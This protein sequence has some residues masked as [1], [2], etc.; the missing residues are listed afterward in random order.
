MT[1]EG[2]AAQKA[3]TA[4]TVM[5]F[6]RQLTEQQLLCKHLPCSQQKMAQILH[7]LVLSQQQIQALRLTL[8]KAHKALAMGT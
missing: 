7:S 6:Q 4:G 3:M 5:M 2:V 8:T 1:L